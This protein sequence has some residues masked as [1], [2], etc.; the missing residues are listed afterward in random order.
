MSNFLNRLA[1][2]SLGT[3]RVAE[4]VVPALFAP[5]L[6]LQR[7][8][9]HVDFDSEVERTANLQETTT[10]PPLHRTTPS[11]PQESSNLNPVSRLSMPASLPHAAPV[12]KEA[13]SLRRPEPLPEPDSAATPTT[14]AGSPSVLDRPA[15]TRAEEVESLVPVQMSG[16]RFEIPETQS[17]EILTRM[18]EP[19]DG[20]EDRRSQP[21]KEF[22]L[23]PD[24]ASYPKGVPARRDHTGPADR[25]APVIRVTIG[26][27]DVR[28]QFPA[29]APTPA[30]RQGRPAAL[31]LEE[32]S[33]QRAEGKR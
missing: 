15:V 29:P 12:Q 7:T 33:K 22:T 31:S 10:P 27:I 1:A 4:P 20:Q 14:R 23:N 6:G 13:V 28:A 25:Q 32:Y 19:R 26:R 21:A 18:A 24:I 2:R 5:N 17:P 3:A 30:V 9:P 11:R 16:L 8:E